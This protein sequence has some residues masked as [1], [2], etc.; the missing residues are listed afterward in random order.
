MIMD[1]NDK[2]REKAI[3][4]KD[5]STNETISVKWNRDHKKHMTTVMLNSVLPS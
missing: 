2:K 4:K 5:P 1:R 3:I